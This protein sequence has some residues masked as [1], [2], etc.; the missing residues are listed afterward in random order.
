MPVATEEMREDAHA[1]VRSVRQDV[2]DW[3]ETAGPNEEPEISEIVDGHLTYHNDYWNIVATYDLEGDEPEL[4]PRDGSLNS[5][6][7]LIAYE[8]LEREA[9]EE[10]EAVKAER[11]NGE[12]FYCDRC[13]RWHEERYYCDDCGDH[14]CEHEVVSAEDGEEVY[15]KDCADDHT[16]N[17]CGKTRT[18][19]QFYTDNGYD[20]CDDCA[21]ELE[22]KSEEAEAE[23]ERE[24]AAEAEA[25][26]RFER[27]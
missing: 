19:V 16:C 9:W 20:L 26:G 13:D 21:A 14:V 25:E 3:A 27:E 18:D 23:H 12:V 7:Q 6:A 8:F 11:D 24:K 15:C 1:T 4:E 22:R 10:W 17:E 2:R 5:L